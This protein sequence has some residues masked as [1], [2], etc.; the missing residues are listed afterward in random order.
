MLI[1]G[2]QKLDLKSS[3]PGDCVVVEGNAIEGNVEVLKTCMATIVTYA[4][5]RV[6]ITVVVVVVGVVVKSTSAWRLDMFRP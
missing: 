5:M 3:H 1:R 6:M 4:R 2:K